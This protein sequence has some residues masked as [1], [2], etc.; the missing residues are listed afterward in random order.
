MIDNI[1]KY[2]P[3]V[4]LVFLISTKKNTIFSCQLRKLLQKNMYIKHILLLLI[5]FAF[6]ITP[7]T[8]DALHKDFFYS[9]IVYIWFIFTMRSPLV[10]TIIALCL[11]LFIYFLGLYEKKKDEKKG[12]N[13]FKDIRKRLLLFTF[14]LST[15]GF[16]Y[17]LILTKSIYKKKWSFID[18][19]LGLNDYECHKTHI[20]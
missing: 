16:L 10:I 18:F 17:F 9:F 7:S 15:C 6:Q 8:S 12:G 4:V 20:F 14:L 2:V 3:A 13:E 11:L 5:I 19:W 1:I